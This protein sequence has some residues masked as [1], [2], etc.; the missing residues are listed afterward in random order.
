MSDA[1]KP[2]PLKENEEGLFGVQWHITDNC[3]QRCRHCYIFAEDN[4]KPLVNMDFAQMQE[5]IQKVEEFLGKLDMHPNWYLTG[6][7]PLLNPDFWRLAEL[8]KEKDQRYLLM[9]NPF[10]LTQ[11]VCRRLKETGCYAYQVSIDGME[12]THDWFRKPGSFRQTLEAIPL[13]HAAGIQ[14]VVGMT[15]SEL[16]YR[17]LPDVMDAMEKARVDHFGFARYVPTSGEKV[18]AIPPMEYRALLETYIRKRR[19]AKLRGSF[20]EFTLKDHLLALYL[21]EEGKFHPPAYC[22]TAGDHMPAG[23]H[24]ANGTM[25]ISADGTVMACRRIESS[26][27]GNIFTDDLMEMWT[28][29][30]RRYRQYDRFSDCA[31]CKLSPWCRGCPAISE[32]VTGDFYG[33]D[34][35]C[36]H[37]VEDESS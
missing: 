7:D 12:K 19:A 29:A 30:K 36:W 17:E 3:D 13:L 22:H 20:T 21:Y 24:C 27:L 2:N 10:H 8:M 9:G 14:S 37:V 6:G 11:D 32:A 26:G 15:V 18:N 4:K 28:E 25:A 23:C 1:K 35:Q 5:V 16:N 34:P 33:R 31:R